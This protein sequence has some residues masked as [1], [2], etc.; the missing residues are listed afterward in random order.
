MLLKKNHLDVA[1]PIFSL[2]IFKFLNAAEM[3][4]CFSLRLVYLNSFQHLNSLVCYPHGHYLDQRD[5][6]KEYESDE[7]GEDPQKAKLSQLRWPRLELGASHQE[8]Q[9]N[10][11]FAVLKWEPTVLSFVG[12]MWVPFN[13]S[14]R[15]NVFILQKGYFIQGLDT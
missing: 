6:R 15:A 9:L 12:L 4:G 13:L 8:T 7:A 3:D 10:F 2:H 14:S 1:L 11:T 5:D